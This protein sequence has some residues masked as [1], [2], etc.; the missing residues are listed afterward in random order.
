MKGHYIK[1]CNCIATC[2]CDTVGRPYPDPGCEGMAGMHI[3]EGHFGKVRLSGLN[4]VAVYHWPGA[5]H[6]G[7]G[8]LQPFIDVRAKPEQ[9]NALLQILSGQAGDAWFEVLASIVTKVHEPQFVPIRFDFDKKKRRARVSIPGLLETVSEPL[10]VP[11]TGKPQRVTL[12]M[13]DGMEYKE[14]EVA[15]S[16][17]LK[18]TGAIPFDHK[19]THSSLADVQHSNKGLLA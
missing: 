12:C 9:R 7:N 6:E 14:M 3:V 5:L 4:W 11:A 15:S 8:T 16:A 2:P 19:N 10:T 1:N 18:S 17:T 13:P